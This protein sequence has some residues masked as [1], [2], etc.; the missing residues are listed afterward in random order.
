MKIKCIDNNR[1]ESYLTIDKTYDVIY[2]NKYGDYYIMDNNG[3][4]WWSNLRFKLLSEI[5]N[6]TINKLLE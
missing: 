5:R 1:W 4:R 3:Y 6:E 2:I